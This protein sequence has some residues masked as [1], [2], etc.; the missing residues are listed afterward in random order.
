M[1]SKLLILAAAM[2]SALA[3]PTPIAPSPFGVLESQVHATYFDPGHLDTAGACGIKYHMNDMIVALP[4][5]MYDEYNIDS[6][7]NHNPLC[8]STMRVWVSFKYCLEEPDADS[9]PVVR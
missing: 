3:T 1:L 8:G 5:A 7:P 6:N 2:V 9:R 4:G